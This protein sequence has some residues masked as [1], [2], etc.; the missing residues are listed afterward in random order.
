MTLTLLHNAILIDCTGRTLLPGLL[1]AHVHVGL[2]ELTTEAMLRHPPAVYAMQVAR[3]IEATLDAGF[4]TVRDAGMLDGGWAH[5]VAA[6]Y[7]RGPRIL[8]SG[9]PISQ[10]GGHGDMR[11]RFQD[12]APADIPGFRT[13]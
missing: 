11:G 8:P 1:D 5:A 12:G 7:V 6:G 4:T 2:T 9:A 10:T 3:A 13:L